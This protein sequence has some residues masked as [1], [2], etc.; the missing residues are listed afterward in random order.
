MKRR[1]CVVC[2]CTEDRA[3]R[4]YGCSWVSTRPALCS[5]CVWFIVNLR[6]KDRLDRFIAAGLI[7]DRVLD[8]QLSAVDTRTFIKARRKRRP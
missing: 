3:C 4:P 5:A 2:G 7:G 1:A 8:V 6:D